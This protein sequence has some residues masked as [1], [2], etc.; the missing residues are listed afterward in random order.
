MNRLFEARE[1]SSVADGTRVAPVFN[2]FDA[3]SP[4]LPPDAFGKASLALGEIRPGAASRPHLHPVVSQVTW[5]L[6]GSLLVR[7]KALSEAQDYELRVAAGQAVL[8]EP[9]TLLQLVNA[10][11]ERT[12]RTLYVV[13]PAYVSLPGADGYDDAVVLD[14]DW[15][16]LAQSGFPMPQIDGDAVKRRRLAALERLRAIRAG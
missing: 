8:T 14:Q 16:F 1:F 6:E 13:T 7:M 10:D 4:A 3:N 11:R 2:A 5:V 9:M 12:A 15:E